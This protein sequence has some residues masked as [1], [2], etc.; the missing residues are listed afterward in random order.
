[1]A[2]GLQSAMVQ[3]DDELDFR[4]QAG[5]T[6]PRRSAT[7]PRSVADSDA[8]DFKPAGTSTRAPRVASPASP[9]IDFRPADKPLTFDELY[10]APRTGMQLPPRR[11]AGVPGRRVLLRQLP[12]EVFP[13]PQ[14]SHSHSMSCTKL[15]GRA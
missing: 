14:K 13:A 8:I 15:R 1:M 5:Q 11:P 4:P 12:R 2:D 3:Y 6:S 10:K 9:G 7:E